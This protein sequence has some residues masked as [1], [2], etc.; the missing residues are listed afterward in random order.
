MHGNVHRELGARVAADLTL[1]PA[2]VL[3]GPRQIGKSTLARELGALSPGSISFDLESPRDRARLTDPEL[4]L[5][6][7]A[8]RLVILDEV[9]AFPDLF[10][11]LRSLIDR[12]RR[13]GRF[14]LLGSASP[15]LIRQASES[16]AGRVS[17]LE[18][19]P[20]LPS[21]VGDDRKSLLDRVSRGGFPD[22]FLATDDSASL[23][24]RLA[25]VRA[26]VE[27]DLPQL[28]L[29]A[30][31]SLLRRLWTMLAHLQGQTLNT[32]QLAS[33][34]GIAPATVRRYVDFMESALLIRLLPAWSGNVK[35]RLVTAP[36]VYLR[37]S[38]VAAALLDLGNLEK[39]MGHPSRGSQWESVVLECLAAWHPDARLSYYR[40]SNGAE[41]DFVIEQGEKRWVVEAKASSAPQVSRGFWS[42]LEDLGVRQAFVCAMVEEAYPLREGVR[43]VPV[44]ALVR[45]D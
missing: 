24:W 19:G 40:T 28:G 26:Y 10:P 2:V 35:K 22:S 41:V 38:G 12:N 29:E 13:P 18:L 32:S 14:L 11:V 8:D 23:R 7:L 4:L 42:S 20:F 5:E 44:T 30:P 17:Y 37:D 34:L 33:S 31:A 25:F 39:A 15:L 27:R 9:Q 45:L 6:E 21:E 3:L 36:R 43:V 16:L 1:F